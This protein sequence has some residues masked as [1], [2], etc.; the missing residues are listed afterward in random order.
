MDSLEELL[1]A[2]AEFKPSPPVENV[3]RIYYDPDSGEVTEMTLNEELNDHGPCLELD[4]E[5]YK[6]VS[7]KIRDLIVIDGQLKNRPGPEKKLSLR[8]SDRGYATVKDNMI[9]LTD[10]SSIEVEYWDKNDSKS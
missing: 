9:F 7:S 3:Y 1:K 10:E 6:Q 5:S 4:A 8:R 2:L